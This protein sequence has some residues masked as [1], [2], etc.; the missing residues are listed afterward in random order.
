MK[1]LQTLTITSKRNKCTIFICMFEHWLESR[2]PFNLL[3]KFLEM[4]YA[5]FES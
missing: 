4:K 1:S 2:F 5:I 3:I